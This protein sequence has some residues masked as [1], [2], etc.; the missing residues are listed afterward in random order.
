MSTYAEDL[1]KAVTRHA[2][3]TITPSM[4]GIASAQHQAGA[5][6][7]HVSADEHYLGWSWAV[8]RDGESMRSGATVG[9][10]NVDAVIAN[11]RAAENAIAAMNADVDL[12]RV[13]NRTTAYLQGPD[14]DEVELTVTE[15]DERDGSL[16]IHL[17][18][19]R[20]VRVAP[21]S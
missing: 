4:T 8:T 7:A 9:R 10:D 5:Y 6:I 1:V 19:G 16:C 18:D 2:G 3:W 11:M 15:P 21:S 20:W 14:G 17:P 12:N 13:L